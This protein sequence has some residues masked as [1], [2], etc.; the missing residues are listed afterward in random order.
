[1]TLAKAYGYHAER[2]DGTEDFK[3]SFKRALRSDCGAVLE[4]KISAEALTPRQTL[5]QMRAAALV[6]A[7]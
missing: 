4:L 2:V 1:M 3:A 6:A 7:E 5:S